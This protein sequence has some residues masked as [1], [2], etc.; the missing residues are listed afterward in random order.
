MS[1][2]Y[3]NILQL[4]ISLLVKVNV[5]MLEVRDLFSKMVY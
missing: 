4:K 5:V 1:V 2:I 3:R